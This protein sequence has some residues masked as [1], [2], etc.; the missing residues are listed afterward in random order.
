MFSSF[1]GVYLEKV[2][3]PVESRTPPGPAFVTGISLASEKKKGDVRP[4]SEKIEALGK[5]IGRHFFFY[6]GKILLL[7]S[8]YFTIK[9]SLVT[10]IP[11]VT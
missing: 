5:Q 2:R 3:V 7:L 9:H 10:K 4:Q 1:S 6:L 11:P 8:F